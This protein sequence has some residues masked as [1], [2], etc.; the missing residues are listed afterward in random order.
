[1]GK[2]GKDSKQVKQKTKGSGHV[3]DQIIT[4]QRLNQSQNYNQGQKK[5]RHIMTSLGSDIPGQVHPKPNR[6]Y[7]H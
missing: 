4:S 2:T 1:M 5:K 6:N 3:Q 7:R